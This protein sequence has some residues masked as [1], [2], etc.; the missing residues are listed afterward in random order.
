MIAGIIRG[1]VS[2]IIL[3]IW[4]PIANWLKVRKALK[5]AELRRENKTLK[6]KLTIVT[7]A[8]GI[9]ED[10]DSLSADELSERM[11]HSPYRRD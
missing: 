1:V 11:R 6:K 10:I 2:A 5:L 7:D 4:S 3:R 8:A 9:D